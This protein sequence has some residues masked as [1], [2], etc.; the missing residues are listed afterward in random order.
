M[1][2]IPHSN[3]VA[4]VKPKKY[5]LFQIAG[6]RFA[7]A[8]SNVR[9]VIALQNLTSVPGMPEYYS[10][11]INLR[12]KIISILDLKIRLG[13]KDAKCE[14]L[15]RRPTVI[16][17]QGGEEPLGLIVDE[18]SEVILLFENQ[19]E[20]KIEQLEESKK[21]GV[22]GAARIDQQELTLILDLTKLRPPAGTRAA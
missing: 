15:V 14:I 19:I 9:E 16:V 13:L 5:M 7:T 22:V 10:G 6:R 21:Q 18:V 2:E 1:S 11:L 4:P 12:G 20:R 17:T 3:D 8:L